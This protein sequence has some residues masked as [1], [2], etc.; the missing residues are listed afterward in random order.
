MEANIPHG[1]QSD[2]NEEEDGYDGEGE[3]PVGTFEE[4]RATEPWWRKNVDDVVRTP[5]TRLFKSAAL[6]A[7]HKY[8]M[9]VIHYS[10]KEKME[11]ALNSGA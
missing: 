6:H 7:K 8:L 10:R 9:K 2:D 1:E 3:E 4:P 5:P 11:A